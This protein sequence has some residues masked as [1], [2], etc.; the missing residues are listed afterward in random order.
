M[1][2]PQFIA[3]CGKTELAKEEL[4]APGAPAAPKKEKKVRSTF[5]LYPTV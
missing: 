5:P 3:V 2:Q 1:N 4:T